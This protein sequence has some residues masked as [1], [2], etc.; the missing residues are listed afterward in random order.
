MLK[1]F[2]EDIIDYCELTHNSKDKTYIM[3]KWTRFDKK[4]YLVNEEIALCLIQSE[5]LDLDSANWETGD[6]HHILNWMG[7]SKIVKIDYMLR[8]LDENLY[9]SNLV[10]KE[11][12]DMKKREERK[13]KLNKL[14]ERKFLYT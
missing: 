11:L 10:R 12:L 14:N 8:Q 5:I 7:R 4:Y 9:M 13:I 1:K 2:L 3:N 6:R